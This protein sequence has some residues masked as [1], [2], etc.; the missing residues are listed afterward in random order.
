MF[1]HFL[2]ALMFLSYD[3]TSVYNDY[4]ISLA[5]V[6][7]SGEYVALTNVCSHAMVLK[8]AGTTL[9][10][11]YTYLHFGSTRFL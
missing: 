5:D 4:N 9:S 8:V 6:R 1:F 7:K 2:E 11:S 3:V 10:G